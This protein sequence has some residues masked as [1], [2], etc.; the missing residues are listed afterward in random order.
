MARAV[1]GKYGPKHD[2][3]GAH[4]VDAGGRLATIVDVYRREC[5]AYV[6]ARLRRFNGDDAGEQALATLEILE[7]DWTRL[8]WEE[9][10][11]A[12]KP[13]DDER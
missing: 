6:M 8:D 2:Y 3:R 1:F 7:R 13:P 5:P 11:L 9:F 10:S 12:A 4:V